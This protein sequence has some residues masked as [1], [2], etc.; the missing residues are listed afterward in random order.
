MSVGFLPCSGEGSITTT[1]GDF[2]TSFG[3]LGGI[4]RAWFFIDTKRASG[5]DC[6]GTIA[7][8]EKDLD[9]IVVSSNLR[10]GH[11]DSIDFNL[12][13]VAISFKDVAF[14]I[15]GCALL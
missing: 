2:F 12:A 7:D 14:F 10:N 11:I 3:S 13:L 6:R 5:C 4:L 1:F 9:I 8:I 15:A